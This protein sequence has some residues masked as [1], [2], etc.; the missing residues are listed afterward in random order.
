MSTK[1]HFGDY[2][3]VWYH[4]KAMTN[5]LS[6]TNVKKK[7]RVTYDSDGVDRFTIH[8]PNRLVHFNCSKNGLYYHDMDSRDITLVN[9]IEENTEGFSNRQIEQ[10]RKAKNLYNI[11]GLPSLRDFKGLIENNMINNCPITL[12]YVNNSIKIYGLSIAA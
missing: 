12:E 3:E 5:I 9:T 2:G 7:Y 11:M 10:A 8:K 4:P 6:M 1:G